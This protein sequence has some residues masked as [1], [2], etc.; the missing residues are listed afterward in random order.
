MNKQRIK[1]VE[2]ALATIA[3]ARAQMEE[4]LNDVREIRDELGESLD[5]MSDGVRN[6]ENGQIMEMD[7]SALEELIDE[8]DG[9]NLEQILAEAGQTLDVSVPDTI[10]A[11]LSPQELATRREARIPQWV[12]D[13]LESAEKSRDAAISAAEKAFG[14]PAGKPEEFVV[15]RQHGPFK[16]KLIPT[17]II[18]VPSI[19]LKLR[20]QQVPSDEGE[21]KYGLEIMAERDLM[22]R[23]ISGNMAYIMARRW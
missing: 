9:F 2:K 7:H 8:I 11:K 5:N 4:A 21:P 18:E 13:R 23:P 17:E 12:K 16:G 6:G 1:R 10:E 15:W 3:T 14:E 22:V 19:G 20:V